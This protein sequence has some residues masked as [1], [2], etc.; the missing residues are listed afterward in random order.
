[1]K[2]NSLS[3]CTTHYALQVPARSCSSSLH[4]RLHCMC[5]NVRLSIWI[6]GED[7]LHTIHNSV[8]SI[9]HWYA[10]LLLG[11][12][13]QLTNVML[14]LIRTHTQ[15][16]HRNTHTD[17][18]YKQPHLQLILEFS[19][20]SL[21]SVLLRLKPIKYPSHATHP[22]PAPHLGFCHTHGTI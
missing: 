13:L 3:L 15:V 10:S 21:N 7:I 18:A 2:I 20:K 14:T 11:S 5:H 4:A 16:T 1:M 9:S 6:C 8:V 17:S 22:A 19:Y 12:H